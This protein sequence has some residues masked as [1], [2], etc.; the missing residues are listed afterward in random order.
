MK[1]LS[2]FILQAEILKKSKIKLI[3]FNLFISFLTKHFKL[4]VP[5]YQNS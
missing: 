5:F 2:N 1:Q 4:S 3:L